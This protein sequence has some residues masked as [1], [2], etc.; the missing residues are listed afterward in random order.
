MRYPQLL[1]EK[2]PKYAYLLG[3]I[4]KQNICEDVF[5]FEVF[6]NLLNEG[7]HRRFEAFLIFCEYPPIQK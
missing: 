1:V 5:K 7:P 4:L 3:E 2:L 6:I